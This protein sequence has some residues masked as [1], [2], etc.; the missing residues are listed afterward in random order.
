MIELEVMGWV[1]RVEGKETLNL[2]C[3]TKIT[4]P[5]HSP[6]HECL[7][8]SWRLAISHA[9]GNIFNLSQLAVSSQ[10]HALEALFGVVRFRRRANGPTLTAAGAELETAVQAFP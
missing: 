6:I 1:I 7:R 8:S 4:H 10:F 3:Y 5:H 2:T 9:A